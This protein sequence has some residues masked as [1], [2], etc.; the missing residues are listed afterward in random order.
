MKI[1]ITGAT[2][3]IGTELLHQLKD[4][5]HEIYCLV[6]KTSI[7]FDKVKDMGLHIIEGDIRDK[8][9]VLRGME[10]CDWVIHLAALYSFWEP[11]NDLYREI[12]VEGTRNVMECALETNASK[13]IHI[14]TVVTFGKPEDTPF[15]EKSKPGPKLFSR[16][17]KTKT[18]IC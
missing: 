2:G 5:G 15:N 18:S 17:A 1:F 13:V 10:G 16:Y 3:F 9:S 6:R 4:T 14:S 11:N 12:N 8:A 7:N